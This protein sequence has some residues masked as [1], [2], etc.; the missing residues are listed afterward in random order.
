MTER[1]DC[2]V[3]G[4][5]VIGLAVARTLALAGREVIVLEAAETIGTHTSSRNS[6]VIHAGLYYRPGSLKARLCVAGKRLLY[7]YCKQH[8]VP[9]R[10]LGKIVVATQ[11]AEIDTLKSY[12]AN[13]A[14]SG[15]TDLDWLSCEQ[16]A[17]LEPE[18]NALA[19][20]VSP[21]TGV[22]D[23][24]ALML[25]LQGEA[26]RHGASVVFLSPVESGEA[27]A[28]QIRL[29]VGGADPITLDCNA[30][31]NSAGLFAQQVARSIAGLPA[32]SIP[33][34][35]YA[36][37]HYY[38]LSGR[39]PFRHL[40]YP[41][42]SNAFLGVH[43]TLDLAGQARFGPDVTW[44]D[45]VDYAFDELDE[46][47]HAYAVTIHRSQGSE[48]PAVVIPLT[49]GSWLM[50]QRNLLYT[51]VT[52]ARKLVVL[53]GSRR[54]L[55]IAV[56]TKGSGRRHTALDHRLRSAGSLPA[57]AASGPFGASA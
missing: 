40:V 25:A 9:H 11:P 50:L 43:V 4:A 24:H 2:V 56:R 48:Y 29:R 33:R 6:E 17:Q 26:E 44:V 7:E 57:R 46:L 3:I 34:A 49:M 10:C 53:V 35:Y 28:G 55:A 1:V 5:G 38:A 12:V 15:V 19:G 13:A 39:S 16:L 31:V 41:L 20:F 51:G 52:R 14:A 21:S 18:V 32:R 42:A 45:K 27:S 54:A 47:A 36:K 22:V 37:A 30:V 8:G 23:S